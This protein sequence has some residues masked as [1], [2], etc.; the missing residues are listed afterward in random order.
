MCN[1]VETDDP[2]DA[3]KHHVCEHAEA[4]C[5]S[6]MPAC[7]IGA[8]DGLCFLTCGL[9]G[10]WQVCHRHTLAS[11]VNCQLETSHGLIWTVGDVTADM[12][13]MV[14]GIKAYQFCSH[15]G[16]SLTAAASNRERITLAKE[17]QMREVRL[18]LLRPAP[19]TTQG[20]RAALRYACLLVC[21]SSSPKCHGRPGDCQRE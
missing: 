5:G 8:S 16:S 18:D 2:I 19:A 1:T 4:L 7:S 14:T 15:V 20:A 3:S 21:L 12:G 10:L 13:E 11:R 17:Q 6:A 9:W